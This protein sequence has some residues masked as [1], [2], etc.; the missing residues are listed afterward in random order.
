LIKAI[1]ER[2]LMFVGELGPCYDEL[3]RADWHPEKDHVIKGATHY[4]IIDSLQYLWDLLPT[5]VK[6]LK[7]S[8]TRD[9][10]IVKMWREEKK[11]K[12]EVKQAKGYD[13]YRKKRKLTAFR[14]RPKIW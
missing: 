2:K 12:A 14:K 7:K 11:I 3:H 13:K 8:L 9:E 6:T 1:G 5:D 10:E 4:H